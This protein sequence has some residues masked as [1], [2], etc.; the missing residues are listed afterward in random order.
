MSD[1][2]QATDHPTAPTPLVEKLRALLPDHTHVSRGPFGLGPTTWTWTTADGTWQIVQPAQVLGGL[3]A[4]SPRP[5]GLSTPWGLIWVVG[6]EA[7]RWRRIVG[8][9]TALGGIAEQDAR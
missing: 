5:V 8:V 7:T 1:H 4:I 9:L 3:I 2:T 6:D